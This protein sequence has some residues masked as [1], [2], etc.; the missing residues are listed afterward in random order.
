M[1]QNGAGWLARPPILMEKHKE[2]PMEVK[3][4]ELRLL[5]DVVLRTVANPTASHCWHQMV[6]LMRRNATPALTLQLEQ[7]L[8]ANV[9]VTGLP[10]FYRATFLDM[11]IGRPEYLQQ[12]G[13]IAL[14]LQPFDADRMVTFLQ[15][16]WQR[17][18]LDIPGRQAFQQRL[19]ELALPAIAASLNSW[20]WQQVQPAQVLKL[21]VIN[22]VRKVA[23][24]APFVSN[25]K[26]PP[27][28]MALQQAENLRQLGYEVVLYSAQEMLGPDFMHYLGS[29]SYTPEPQF[30]TAGWDKYL[31]QGGQVMT[32]DTRFSLL[33]RWKSLLGSMASFDPDLVM[34]VG[35]YAGLAAAAYPARPVLSLGI[36]SLSPM[37]PADVWLTA[38]QDLHGLEA[39]QWT[40]AFPASQ[41]YYH[42]Y[43]VQRPEIQGNHTRASL[44]LAQ[45][46]LLLVTLVNESESRIQGAWAKVMLQVLHENPQVQWLII[47][48]SGAMPTALQAA[49]AEQVSCIAFCTDAV[50]YLACSDIYINPPMMGGGFAVA[51]AMA[52]G[53]PALSLQ[54][55]DGGDK[56][57]NAAQANLQ[58]YFQTLMLWLNN[59][60][61]RKIAGQAMQKHFDDYLDLRKAAASLQGACE[62][63]LQRFHLRMAAQTS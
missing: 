56:L 38:Q 31:G 43:R 30:V 23:L 1:S 2:Q 24:I 37:S 21:R 11:L 26:H 18:L 25:I 16:S 5:D 41:A 52:L 47:G 44:G 17:V 4:E 54:G 58:E 42:S 10:G 7:F 40:T 19:Q 36:N 27:T 62:L 29:R 51:E 48:G 6:E 49:S 63:A 15:Y 34:F 35:L 55:S 12:A 46:K 22:E 20:I 9:A 3:H 45:D 32:G 28:L 57:G 33:Q 8:Q 13:Q 61:A 60:N 59:P 50:K 14:S 39:S 53:L